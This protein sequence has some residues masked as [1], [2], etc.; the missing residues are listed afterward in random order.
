MD[1]CSV[2]FEKGRIFSSPL[3]LKQVATLFLDKWGVQCAK[4]G[5]KIV[6]YYHA[7]DGKE[8]EGRQVSKVSYQMSL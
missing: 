3:Q 1:A 6:F 5:K 7:L 2:L 4:H 8:G